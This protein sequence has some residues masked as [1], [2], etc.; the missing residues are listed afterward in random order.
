MVKRLVAI[1]IFLAAIP[2]AATTYYVDYVG[3]SDVNAGTSKALPWQHAHG[4]TN[5]ASVCLSTVPAGGDTIIFKGGVTWVS[6]Y[7]WKLYGGSSSMV[8]YTT[9]HTWYTGTA[10][11]QPVFDDQGAAPAGGPSGGMINGA[12]WV[13]MNDFNVVNCGTVSVAN[14]SEC[15]IWPNVHDVAVTNNSFAVHY[16]ITLYFVYTTAGDYYNITITG[17]DFTGSS[18]A[19]WMASAATAI[20]MHTVNVSS[21]VFHDYHLDMVGG[22]HGNGLHYY[23]SGTHSDSTQ[24]MDG[25]T[26]CDNRS[27]GDFSS[28]GVKYTGGTTGGGMTSLYFVEGSVSGLVCNNDFTFSDPTAGYGTTFVSLVDV[29]GNS[30]AHPTILNV[31][32]NTLYNPV[33]NAMSAGIYVNAITTGSAVNIENNIVAGMQNSLY[34]AGAETGAATTSN[35]NLLDCT[36]GTNKLISTYYTYAQWAAIGYDTNS[37]TG[38]DPLFVSAPGNE[39]LTST[40]PARGTAAN[41]T[42]LGYAVLDVDFDG[43]ARPSV[44]AWD[45]GAFQYGA[46]TSTTTTLTSSSYSTTPGTNVTL[47]ATV[48]PSAATGTVT[49]YDSTTSTTLGTGTLSSGVATISASFAIAETHSVYAVYSGNSTY[50][51]STSSSISIVVSGTL[52]SI[53]VT[54]ATASIYIGGT[55]QYVATCTLSTSATYDCTSAVTWASSATAYATIT[56]SGGLATGVAVGSTTITA[57]QSSISSPGV[58]LAVI[59]RPAISGVAAAGFWIVN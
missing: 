19:I 51:A 7:P 15:V 56:S 54:P 37:V 48:A 32:N 42:S 31:V 49:F 50:N 41:L 35:Y 6:S 16:W 44:S 3:G 4:M 28:Y 55:Q 21:N 2:C 29:Q 17:N 52:S 47:T 58:T 30:N 18:N 10:W 9:D 1:L 36:S 59:A 40:S 57:T 46:L 23:S 39:R 24:Y 22:T 43:V 25:L 26:F 27:Y 45:I 11:S 14:A 12:N 53:A 33:S 13:T 5:C 34:F 20:A 38:V 8:T